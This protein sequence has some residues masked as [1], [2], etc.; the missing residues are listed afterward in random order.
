MDNTGI[1]CSQGKGY[2]KVR[3]TGLLCRRKGEGHKMGHLKR[4]WRSYADKKSI[5]VVAL[6]AI[7]ISTK[8]LIL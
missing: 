3:S 8:H 6:T 1:R 2:R 5:S 7:S 4:E